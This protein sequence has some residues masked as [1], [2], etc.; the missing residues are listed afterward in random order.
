ME[1]HNSGNWI[2]CSC[3]RCWLEIRKRFWYCKSDGDCR[4]A[5]RV[6]LVAAEDIIIFLV[7]TTF[8]LL[9]RRLISSNRN[10]SSFP[11]IRSKAG[12]GSARRGK[13]AYLYC[14]LCMANP[15]T[16]S[17]RRTRITRCLYIRAYDSEQI[18]HERKRYRL[19]D[20][21]PAKVTA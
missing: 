8:P 21:F 16:D 2:S 19:L 14:P 7:Y 9:L 11:N 17:A 18:R 3:R 10:Q 6:K 12:R 4:P 15:S 20:S 13:W 5:T 1:R